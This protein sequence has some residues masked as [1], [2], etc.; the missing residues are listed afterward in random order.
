[1]EGN[2]PLI[3]DRIRR[4][5]TPAQ[6]ARFLDETPSNVHRWETGARKIGQ[7]KLPKIAEK[8]GVPARELRPDLA[9]MFGG[10]AE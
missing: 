10:A 2:G 8:T 6:Y 9:E 3:A 7:G 4:G 5:M 1:M